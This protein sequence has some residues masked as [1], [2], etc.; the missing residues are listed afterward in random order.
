MYKERIKRYR[1]VE[2]SQFS[3]WI[4]SIFEICAG[5]PY[6]TFHVNLCCITVKNIGHR[7]LVVFIFNYSA[8]I[9]FNFI[10]KKLTIV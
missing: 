4:S 1:F 6:F 10:F 7:R 2:I 5:Y 9:S 3:L 8:N